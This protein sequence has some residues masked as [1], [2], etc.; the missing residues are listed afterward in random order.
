MQNNL[1]ATNVIKNVPLYPKCSLGK[2]L[3]RYYQYHYLFSHNIADYINYCR[4]MFQSACFYIDIEKTRPISS[5]LLNIGCNR[6]VDMVCDIYLVKFW[7][8]ENVQIS[9]WGYM[10]ILI[11]NHSFIL[12]VN[13]KTQSAII[14]I[15]TILNKFNLCIKNI[16][17]QEYCSCN[18]A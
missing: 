11:Y 1:L 10:F 5:Y 15:A 7:I 2:F 8:C 6:I 12:F 16:V 4:C 13:R 14:T 17:S 9:F 18:A 3:S